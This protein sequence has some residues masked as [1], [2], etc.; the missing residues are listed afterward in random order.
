MQ[1]FDLHNNIAPV[2]SIKPGAVGATGVGQTGN[3]VNRCGCN[4]VEFLM[5]VGS[6]TATNATVAG[7]ILDCATSNGS[8]VTVS[9]GNLIGSAPLVGAASTRTSGVS[10]NL[11][12]RVGYK[13]LQPFVKAAIFSTVSAGIIVSGVIILGS[14]SF[15][16]TL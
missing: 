13:G 11:V 1:Q 4:A 3:V 10:K 14:P 2:V 8:F 9:A 6:I 7:S 12:Q 15:R 5:T 16:P